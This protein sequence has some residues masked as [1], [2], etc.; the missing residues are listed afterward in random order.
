MNVGG[1]ERANDFNSV[2]TATWTKS[3]TTITKLVH[4]NLRSGNESSMLTK[5][6]IAA[7]KLIHASDFNI[8]NETMWQ[9]SITGAA[10]SD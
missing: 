10:K 9:E 1:P 6:R 4:V 5:L 7:T 3:N 8:D 2:N